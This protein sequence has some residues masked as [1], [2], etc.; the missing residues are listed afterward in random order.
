MQNEGNTHMGLFSFLASD[1]LVSRYL[2]LSVE[3]LLALTLCL[4]VARTA[5]QL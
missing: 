2:T 5:I 4:L 3:T 1:R